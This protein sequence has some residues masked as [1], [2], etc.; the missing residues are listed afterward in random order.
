MIVIGKNSGISLMAIPFCVSKNVFAGWR[1]GVRGIARGEN[2][3]VG[4]LLAPTVFSWQ[5]YSSLWSRRRETPCD[6]GHDSRYD[7]VKKP[8]NVST[9]A[10]PSLRL[11]PGFSSGR[12][13]NFHNYRGIPSRVSIV[14]IQITSERRFP[15]IPSPRHSSNRDA[16]NTFVISQ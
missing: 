11:Y 4:A 16:H 3:G 9:S 5:H 14:G 13:E 6:E 7:L 10:A 8:F 15:T 12:R 2:T 1:N